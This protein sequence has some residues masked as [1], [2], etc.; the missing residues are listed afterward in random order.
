[1]INQQLRIITMNKRTFIKSGLMAGAGLAAGNKI[2][3]VGNQA[4]GMADDMPLGPSGEYVLLT[5]P[6]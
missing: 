5:K 4:A 1:M 3:G 6:P 2:F